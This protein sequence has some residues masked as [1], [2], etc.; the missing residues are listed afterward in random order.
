[1][2]EDHLQPGKVSGEENLFVKFY[3]RA[4]QN[5]FKSERAGRPV[6]DEMT[7]VS[8]LIPGI[9][10]TAVDSPATEEHKRRF[11]MQWARFNSSE[12]DVSTDGWPVEQWPALN[13]AQVEELKAMKFMTVESLASASDAQIQRI[14]MGGYQ[15]REKARAAIGVAKDSADAQHYAVENARLRADIEALQAQI[16]AIQCSV[17]ADGQERAR[18]PGRPRKHSD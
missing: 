16:Q 14:G 3:K 9:D 2:L 6:F 13:V 18:G 11:P 5:N 17:S 10:T 8:I 7:Y 1:M 4:V 15:L 12:Q